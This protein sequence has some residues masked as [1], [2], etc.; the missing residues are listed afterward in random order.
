MVSIVT[1]RSSVLRSV[2]LVAIGRHHRH[3]A[4]GLDLHFEKRTSDNRRLGI[5]HKE[6]DQGSCEAT[7]RRGRA[8]LAVQVQKGSCAT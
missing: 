3:A 5:G 4:L 1:E 6:L 8:R 2:A 7:K